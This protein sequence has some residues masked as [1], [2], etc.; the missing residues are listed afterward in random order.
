MKKEI[1]NE[2]E[3]VKIQVMDKGIDL[4]N[5]TQEVKCCDRAVAKLS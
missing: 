3:A 4:N 2:K 1:K 5:G